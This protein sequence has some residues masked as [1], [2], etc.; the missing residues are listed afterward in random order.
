MEAGVDSSIA[1]D[2][3]VHPPTA[4][5]AAAMYARLRTNEQFPFLDFLETFVEPVSYFIG[6]GALIKEA[7]DDMEWLS[8]SSRATNT[9]VEITLH[10]DP[11]AVIMSCFSHT[12][13]Q[14]L[15][16]KFPVDSMAA[17]HVMGPLVQWRY[18]FK[19]LR[20]V[21]ANLPS[22]STSHASNGSGTTPSSSSLSKVSIDAEGKLKITHML[23]INQPSANTHTRARAQQGGEEQEEQGEDGSA[24]TRLVVAQFGLLPLAE[25]EEEDDGELRVRVGLEEGRSDDDVSGLGHGY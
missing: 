12:Q 20:A 8:S 5:A 22:S 2:N 21:F 16:V 19:H 3:Q 17:L 13:T 25:E 14:S 11:G 10:R 6:P 9:G 7:V 23:K 4:A 15:E 18:H 1:I 24:Y